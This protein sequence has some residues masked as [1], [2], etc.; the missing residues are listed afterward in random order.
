MSF[1]FLF[2]FSV[3]V[4]QGA[5]HN[6]HL[7]LEDLPDEMGEQGKQQEHE[8]ADPDQEVSRQLRGF[9]FFLVHS[10]RILS[11]LVV[12]TA[13]LRMAAVPM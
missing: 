10:T 4:G 5:A 11:G 13:E 6:A 1:P 9:D 7:L 3:F 8:C 2:P 12:G